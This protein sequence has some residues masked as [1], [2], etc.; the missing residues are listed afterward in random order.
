ML[1]GQQNTNSDSRSEDHRRGSLPSSKGSELVQ[2]GQAVHEGG[3]VS[4]QLHGLGQ[5]VGASGAGGLHSLLQGLHYHLHRPTHTVDP[6]D[7]RGVQGKNAGQCVTTEPLT[8]HL[9]QGVDDEKCIW[10]L[11][12]FND[13]VYVWR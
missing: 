12:V 2:M 7:T 4:D 6:S 9:A 5:G 1:S 13:D 11:Q 8:R 10:A 3:D